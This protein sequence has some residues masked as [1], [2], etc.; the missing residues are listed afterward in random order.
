MGE[1]GNAASTVALV[2]IFVLM[3]TEKVLPYLTKNKDKPNGNGAKRWTPADVAA[4]VERSREHRAEREKHD[5]LVTDIRNSLIS[6]TEQS[7]KLA[8]SVDRNTHVLGRIERH[9]SGDRA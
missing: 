3:A 5:A 7:R 1:L 8:D 6:N 9:L 2:L 4:E